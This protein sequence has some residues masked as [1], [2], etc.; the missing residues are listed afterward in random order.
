MVVNDDAL[1]E[2]P[3]YYPEVLDE[4]AF[5]ADVAM[6]TEKPGLE[7]FSIRIE[8][9]DDFVGVFRAA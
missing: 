7:E 8:G 3:I 9:R 4:Q 1:L 6:V 5:W 2:R